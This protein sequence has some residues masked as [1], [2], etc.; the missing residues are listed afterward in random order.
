MRV[1]SSE[2]LYENRQEGEELSL[3]YCNQAEFVHA[4]PADRKARGHQG[5]VKE[6]GD[7]C[8]ACAGKPL[9]QR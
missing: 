8:T 1:N 6:S 3:P 4:A 5:A 2:C 9:I 7:Y